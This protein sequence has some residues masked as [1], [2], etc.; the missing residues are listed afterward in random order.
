MIRAR[1]RS[2]SRGS[3]PCG[4]ETASYRNEVTGLVAHPICACG[5]WAEGETWQLAGED[6]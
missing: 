1:R 2:E 4:I 3:A 6:Y 5:Y